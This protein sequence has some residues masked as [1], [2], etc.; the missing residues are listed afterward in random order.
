M[1]IV[2]HIFQN[3]KVEKNSSSSTLKYMNENKNSSA[4]TPPPAPTRP[5]PLK[6]PDFNKKVLDPNAQENARFS[7]TK[8]LKPKRP[9]DYVMQGTIFFVLAVLLLASVYF[10]Y[11]FAADFLTDANPATEQNLVFENDLVRG[12]KSRVISLEAGASKESV[13][14]V[15]IQ[16]L[17]NERVNSGEVSLIMPSYL[18]DTTINGQRRLVSELQRG[19]DFFFTFAIRSPLNL[20]TISAQSYAIGTAG[21][22]DVKANGSK[23]FFAFS[24]SSPPDATREMINWEPNMYDDMHDILKLKELNGDLNFRDLSANNHLLRVG[25]DND[26]VVMVYGFGAP[27]TIIVA[28]DADTFEFIYQHLK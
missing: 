2:K 7:A 10:V 20:R 23:N 16:A 19:D 11:N 4:S 25:S 12:D 24:V 18:R 26:G 5:A 21:V 13:R 28:P 15:V 14:S 9:T 22:G 17:K 1:F 3:L 6:I 27:K 8:T